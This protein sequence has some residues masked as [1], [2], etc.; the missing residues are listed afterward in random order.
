MGRK[1]GVDLGTSST[2]IYR[3]GRGI[4]IDEATV[5]AVDTESGR[6]I[7]FGNDAKKIIGK[8]PEGVETVLPVRKGTV[9][10][11]DVSAFL[12][13]E[14]FE[15][16]SGRGAFN[17]PSV[18]M[19]VPHVITDVERL[20]V[21]KACAEA[22]AS[23]VL[24][25]ETPVVAALGAA[26][27]V[28]EARGCMVVDIGGGT[29]EAAVISL[30]GVLSSDA[31][32]VGGDEFNAEISAFLRRK[33]NL[34]VSDT[35][36]EEVK[37]KI[38]SVHPSVDKGGMEVSGRDSASGLPLSVNVTS[39]DVRTAFDE[40]I[41]D[42]CEC[43]KRVIEKVGPEICSDIYTYGI[44]LTGG[45]ARLGGLCERLKDEIGVEFHIADEPEKCC[46]NGL[47]KLL[48]INVAPAFTG[49]K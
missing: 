19:S 39:E 20:A 5:A 49:K 2:R 13:G 10:E 37:I 26:L 23:S 47:G 17:R 1:I 46:V 21:E 43:I 6:V 41:A 14:L 18:L 27:P 25:V 22:G 4:V 48:E 3:K 7:A 24:L 15:R 42:V 30:G 32:R 33:Y 16:A 12:L 45:S 35:A 28:D 8:E 31:V 34:V 44:T 38:G 11:Y 9:A 29:T 36:A 40:R